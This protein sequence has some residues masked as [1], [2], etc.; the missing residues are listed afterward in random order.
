MSLL[1][2]LKQEASALVPAVEPVYHL[3][4][5][6]VWR[7]IKKLAGN[8]AAAARDLGPKELDSLKSM[9]EIIVNDTE[10]DPGFQH[11]VGQW[12]F[13]HACA[14]LSAALGK[15]LLA[16]IPRLEQDTIETLIQTAFASITAHN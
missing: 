2:N 6:L 16:K 9:A 1:D 10:K 14:T 5:A 15:G 7:D 8:E 11:A 12:K 3:V 4:A 13:G